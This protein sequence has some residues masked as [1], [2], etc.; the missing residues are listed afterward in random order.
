MVPKIRTIKQQREHVAV[1]EVTPD[2]DLHEWLGVLMNDFQTRY[3]L[4]HADD[5]VIWGQMVN[6]ELV[7]ARERAA[8]LPN[9]GQRQRLLDVCPALHLNTLW[10]ARLFDDAAMVH[11][12]RDGGYWRAT[13]FWTPDQVALDVSAAQTFEAVIDECQ[14]TWG[15]RDAR[16]DL[17]DFTVMR[18]GQQGLVH[19]VPLLVNNNTR[20]WLRVRH[21]VA[22]DPASGFNRIA[23]SRLVGFEQ[24]ECENG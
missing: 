6:G 11:L 14:L 8:Q 3:L 21:Y 13:L 23:G 7:T 19:V 22:E 1:Q 2:N 24:G 17:A 4:A 15:E 18:D 5:G 10:E 9:N 16:Y 12:W 20:L